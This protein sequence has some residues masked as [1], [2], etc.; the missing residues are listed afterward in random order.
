MKSV[1][2]MKYDELWLKSREVKKKMID[3]LL[4]HLRFLGFNKLKVKREGIVLFE[5]ENENLLKAVP[6]ISKIEKRAVYSFQNKQDI[7]DLI[8]GYAKHK[9]SAFNT[10]GVRVKRKHKKHNFRSRDIEKEAGAVIVKNFNKKVDLKNPD[11]WIKVEIY[12][13]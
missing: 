4:E 3:Y 11:L 5:W 12:E 8:V 7:I 2:W 13:N 1:L 10:F 9:I 6:G